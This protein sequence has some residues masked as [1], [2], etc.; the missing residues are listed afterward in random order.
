MNIVNSL[1][2]TGSLIAIPALLIA[3]YFYSKV[4][5]RSA[6]YRADIDAHRAIGTSRGFWYQLW[7]LFITP[8]MF[9]YNLG[10]DAIWFVTEIFHFAVFL[11]SVVFGW[12]K[13]I[14]LELLWPGLNFVW[15]NFVYYFWQWPWQQI[16]LV[17]ANLVPVAS[18]TYLLAGMIGTGSALILI[19]IGRWCDYLL[20]NSVPL[21]MMASGALATSLLA[22]GSGI[23]SSM[24]RT[25]SKKGGWVT[26]KAHIPNGKKSVVFLL[27]YAMLSIIL[28]IF[29]WIIWRAGWIHQWGNI[30]GGFLSGPALLMSFIS[31][32]NLIILGFATSLGSHFMLDNSTN[33]RN[34]SAPFISLSLRNLGSLI[35]TAPWTILNALI[36]TLIPA[37]L[38]IGALKFT[39]Q[40]TSFVRTGQENSHRTYLEARKWTDTL[41]IERCSD[42]TFNN[43]LTAIQ[44]KDAKSNDFIRQINWDKQVWKITG[45]KNTFLDFTPVQNIS[46][47]DSEVSYLVSKLTNLQK[48]SSAMVSA[49]KKDTDSLSAQKARTENEL[50][51]V[52]SIYDRFKAKESD[53]LLALAWVT[54]STIESQFKYASAE[55][56]DE[57]LN[58]LNQRLARYSTGPEM[59]KRQIKIL[60]NQIANL[61]TEIGQTRKAKFMDTIAYLIMGIFYSLLWAFLISMA[62]VGFV[63]V[64]YAIYMK[65][66]TDSAETIK[67]IQ[68]W[69]E[70]KVKNKNQPLMSIIILLLIAGM[71]FNP[72]NLINRIMNIA[73]NTIQNP[74]PLNESIPDIKDS[75][76]N[77]Q[78]EETLQNPL[79]E[80]S[81]DYSVE[82]ESPVNE[83][84]TE[85]QENYPESGD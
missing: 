49:M 19:H 66:R 56:F 8:M 81:V 75:I 80:K 6:P 22:F 72:G 65:D 3:S 13:W 25:N 63:A 5:G 17:F 21:V 4:S 2:S 11:F 82:N 53:S 14:W 24:L 59:Q 34:N 32:L 52:Q 31:I 83:L 85:A 84:S 54:D 44:E 55:K 42:S 30:L 67:L 58:D 64:W 35:F 12:F 43:Y 10:V 46:T 69:N 20:G 57:I 47:Y 37:I 36:L 50:Q 29:E 7:I 70:Q 9:L 15:Q 18:S 71:A 51:K 76:K 26:V 27:T 40:I 78:N 68:I 74:V 33:V 73:N 38:F 77:N 61:K 41:N 60:N 1:L 45:I 62:W 16:Q 23:I 39:Q 28:V 79:E 48:D